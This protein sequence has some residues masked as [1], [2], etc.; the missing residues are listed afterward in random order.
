MFDGKTRGG[1]RAVLS[2]LLF[3]GAREEVMAD[4]KQAG[5]RVLGQET[6][7]FGPV[8]KVLPLPDGLAEVT[9]AARRA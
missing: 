3:A 1:L 9:A 8:L 7:P 6:S 4:L 2:L 5:I